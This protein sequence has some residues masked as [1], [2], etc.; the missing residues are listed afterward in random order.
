VFVGML[1]EWDD[2]VESHVTVELAVACL[3]REV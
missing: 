3:D 1:K 2:L